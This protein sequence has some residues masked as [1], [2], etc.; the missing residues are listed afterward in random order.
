MSK[1]FRDRPMTSLD[2]A[3]Y[4]VEYVI[5]HKGAHHLRTA[6][7]DLTWYQFYLL[8]VIAF[9]SLIMLSL[10]FI[11]YFTTKWTVK[12]LLNLLFK[13]NKIKNA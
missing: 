12:S 9:I 4:W 11:C 7:M 2:K 5:R 13:R 1:I 8:D 10:I 3:V 6:A